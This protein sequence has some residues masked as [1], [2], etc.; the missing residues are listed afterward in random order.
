MIGAELAAEQARPASY[1]ESPV[2]DGY[3]PTELRLEL[4][5]NGRL[6][7]QIEPTITEPS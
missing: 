5:H 1:A 4:V 2:Q 6:T 7:N 3:T